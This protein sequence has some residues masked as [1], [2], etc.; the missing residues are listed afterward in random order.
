MSLNTPLITP[1]TPLFFLHPSSSSSIMGIV[2]FFHLQQ[3]PK[4]DPSAPPPNK[5]YRFFGLD[6]GTI[7]TVES[8]YL[9][10]IYLCLIRAT[11]A[12][13][14]WLSF[15]VYF[16]LLASQP[17]KFLRKQAWK[18]LGDV[19]FH[20]YLGMAIYFTFAAYHTLRYILR[21]RD[22]LARWPKALQLAHLMV[23][24]TVLTFPL[25]CTVVYLYW[26]LPALPGWSTRPL[27]R[28]STVTFYMLNTVF[29]Y[30]ELGVSAVRPRPWSHLLVVVFILGCYLAFHSILVAATGGKVWVY[31]VLKYS[32]SINKGWISAVRAVGLCVLGIASFCLTQLLLWAKCR[33]FGGLKLPA[34]KTSTELT[35][36]RDNDEIQA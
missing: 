17:S 10:P 36:L 11:L 32:L 28:W 34:R 19:M 9:K 3:D 4:Q 35:D 13:Y 24:T 22:S 7:R 14:S 25:F 29:S 27:S 18:L 31:T 16:G 33:Y 20:S 12:L 21:D 1:P 26:T 6:E 15:G 8:P 5:F 30:L 23:Q 2:S